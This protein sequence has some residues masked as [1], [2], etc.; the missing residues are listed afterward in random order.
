MQEVI[1]IDPKTTDEE[2]VHVLERCAINPQLAVVITKPSDFALAQK[3]DCD[4]V[5]LWDYTFEKA[6]EVAVIVST[7]ADALIVVIGE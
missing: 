6:N 5:T 2:F 3:F 1:V 7:E 4:I